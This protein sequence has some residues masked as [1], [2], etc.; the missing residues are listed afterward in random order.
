MTSSGVDDRTLPPTKV[1]APTIWTVGDSHAGHLQGLLY[2]LHDRFGFGV[3]LIETPGESFPVLG[4]D[5]TAPRQ[6]IFNQ[7]LERLRPGDVIVTARLLLQRKTGNPPYDN[8]E[9]WGDAL[10]ELAEQMEER[11]VGV[12]VMGP[13][14]MFRFD[15]VG[16][17]LTFIGTSQCDVDRAPIAVAAGKHRGAARRIPKT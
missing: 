6:L 5:G 14:P 3:H 11:G 16:N 7:I 12:V 17:C 1:G 2:M 13:L 15:V 9:A 4:G 8:I 10:V